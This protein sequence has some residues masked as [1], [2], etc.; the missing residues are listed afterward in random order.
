MLG[1]KIKHGCFHVSRLLCSILVAVLCLSAVPVYGA[2]NEKKNDEVVYARPSV[3]GQ[4]GEADGKLVDEKGTPVLLRGVST[5][6][7][8]W[9]PDMIDP[10]LFEELSTDWDSN[11][12]RLAVY[13]KEYAEGDKEQCLALTRKGIEAAIAADQY[14]IVDWHVL[15]EQNPNVYLT[16][17]EEFFD[18]ICDEYGDS[19]NLIFE[20]CNEPNGETTWNDIQDYANKVI[21]RIREKC[22]DSLILVGTP[23]YDKNLSSA[24][25]NPLKYS[26]IMYVLHFYAST[27]GKDLMKEL[28][29]AEIAGFPVF[30]SECG[31]S[32]SSGDG[33]IDYAACTEWFALLRSYNISFAVWSFSNKNESSALLKPSFDPSKPLEGDNLSPCG[34]WVRELIKG[35]KPIDIP[36]PTGSS[37]DS[38]TLPGFFASLDYK[39]F[40]H[41]KSWPFMAL[42][43]LLLLALV[44]LILAVIHA[45]VKKKHPTYDTL[46]ADQPDD[47]M[48]TKERVKA[49]FARILL[50][51][52]V[53]ATMVYLYWRVV[54]SIPQKSGWIAIV[55][56]II[57]LAVEVLGFI[58]SLALYSNLMR[59]KNHPLPKIADEEYPE[60]DVFIATYNEPAEL[61][62]KTINGCVHM[63]YPDPSKV[64]IW[65][66]DDN[67]RPEMRALAEEMGIGYF[68]RPDN[69]GAKAGNLN[70]AMAHTSAPYVVTLD[71]DMI[72]RSC[73]LLKTIPYFVDAKKRSDAL[74]EEKRVKLGLL[75]TPQCFYD[76]DVFQ[77][78][79]YAE[80]NAPNEQ[81]FFYRT[82][83]VAK[84]ATNSVIYGGSNTV[85]A[86]EALDAVGG[87]YTG[88]ITEDFATGVL[89]EAAGYVSLATPE[90]LASGTTPHTY[91]EHIQQRSRWGRGVISTAK[92][93]K[94]FRMKGLSL[95][96]KFSYW[97][98]VIYWY[99]P[100]KSLVYLLSPLMF[101]VFA[102]PV[103]QCN[104]MDLLLFW[105]PMFVM[106]EVCLRAFSK[107]SISLKWSGIYEISVMP[108]L[109]IPILK[110]TFG[111]SSKVFAVTDKSKRSAKRKVDR[112]EM[113]PFLILIGLSVFGIIRSFYVLGSIRALGVL[114]LLF[115]LFRN[116]YFL[117][118]SLFLVDGRD[119]NSEPVT[120]IDAEMATVKREAG[121]TYYGVT[122]RLNEHAVKVF[123]DEP[124]GIEVGDAVE[125]TI[126]KEEDTAAMRGIL[127]EQVFP[128]N[129]IGCVCSMEI[130]DFRGQKNEYLEILYN[131]IP[132]LPQSLHRD[133][134][135]IRHLMVNIAHRVLKE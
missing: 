76:P 31:L 127:T 37:A 98:S 91:K 120:V 53:F 105:L 109:L 116:L 71:A 23:D 3:N 102:I 27:H 86:R 64:H 104:W 108:F 38:G 112:R 66:C 111:G 4:L 47:P 21:P 61:L 41:A 8:T 72:P 85:L 77:H 28:Q 131:R 123:L 25:R 26:N 79:L 74:P 46:Y 34:Q 84:T 29:S 35:V 16:Q 81:D 62:R 56:N 88:S 115:W 80:K 129:G 33:T 42:H 54:F 43:I 6:G 90:P 125:I 92:S 78:A 24:R 122:T 99:S 51:A 55:C 36:V 121:G 101:A 132:S 103:F 89:I 128:R 117:I 133:T 32:E 75:Q 70:H 12:I 18:I 50:L 20:I 110:E 100:L 17:A 63:K 94:L 87:F 10:K 59:K 119:S 15:E 69:K 118:M 57:L 134:G 9:F 44:V 68:D 58:E 11:L 45:S 30:V 49:F 113:I 67:R 135:I 73:F 22:P 5:H 97:S 13:S 130:I 19:K 93:L 39:D 40:A 95:A 106:Q 65:L 48:E 7:I 124:D 52:G 60:V 82:I 96:Q 114:I 107:N 126:E 1:R 14:V 2:T 83:E